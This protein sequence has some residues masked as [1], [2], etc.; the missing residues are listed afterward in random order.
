M[1]QAASLK[2]VLLGSPQITLD[3]ETLTGFVSAKAKALLCYLALTRRVHARSALGALLW[4]DIPEADAKSQ[5][6]IALSNLRK[7]TG[8]HLRIERETVEFDLTRPY[9]LDV[10]EF[11]SCIVESRRDLSKQETRAA[12]A[13]LQAATRL[14]RDD[15]LAGMVVR[16]A[17]E[18]EEWLL[19]QRERLRL[20][21]LDALWSSSELERAN[22]NSESALAALRRVIEME[23]WREEAHRELMLLY[24]RA[25]KYAP[26]LHQ[27]EK[28]RAAL[29]NELAVE[30]ARETAHLFERIRAAAQSPRR[31]LPL[32]PDVFVGRESEL[33]IIAQRFQNETR[34]LTL[35]GPGG[36]GKTRL[37]MQA[38]AQL[39]GQFLNGVFFV[40]LAEVT[41]PDAAV[42]A[43]AHAVQLTFSG[44]ETP[45]TQVLNYLQEK[46]LLLTL[47]NFEQVQN[48]AEIVREI[49][50]H[51]PAL[52]VLVTSRE[53]LNL[54]AEWLLVVEGLPTTL[55]APE[56]DAPSAAVQLFAER[57]RQIAPEFVLEHEATAVQQ[58]VA[59]LDGMPLAIELAAAWRRAYSATEIAQMVESDLDFLATTQPDARPAHASIRAV[60]QHSWTMLSAAE[61]QAFRAL[62][63]FHGG[64]AG[65]AA[66]QVAGITPQILQALADKSLLRMVPRADGGTLRFGLHELLR[67]YALEK[68]DQAVTGKN[69]LRTKHAD[70]YAQLLHVQEAAL[71]GAAVKQA[72][73]ALAREYDNLTAAWEW[74]CA[75]SPP[76]LEALKRMIGALVFFLEVRA[77][78]LAGKRMYT[79]AVECLESIVN[80]NA[81]LEILLARAYT[82]LSWFCFRLAEFEPGRAASERAL[83]LTQIHD[84]F[85]YIAYPLLFLGAC[86]FGAGKLAAARDWTWQSVQVFRRLND[87]FGIAGALNNLGQICLA[88]GDL[89]AA[90]EHLHRA[91]ETA[92]QAEIKTLQCNVLENL[93]AL[94]LRRAELAEAQRDLEAC[95]DLARELDLAY[96]TA[97][98]QNTLTRVCYERGD[99]VRAASLLQEAQIIWQRV[100]DR[101]SLTRTLNQ[102]ADLAFARGD[103]AQAE[104]SYL[105][106]LE[107]AHQVD[108]TTLMLNALAGLAELRAAQGDEKTALLWYTLLTQHEATE[109]STRAHAARRLQELTA[110][111]DAAVVASRRADA[112]PDALPKIVNE[113]LRLQN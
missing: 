85:E 27:Y 36:I 73:A 16:D 63:I 90:Q 14:Y 32:V 46:E 4:G 98:I 107:T 25:G 28:C 83:A 58:L 113:I 34:L 66:R 5:L 31:N 109:D 82:G 43:I 49:L 64:F 1:K 52:R 88:L 93:G 105:A 48:G 95:L 110:A 89:D 75:Q 81:D 67:Q 15:L 103:L 96:E 99:Y 20:M 112:M 100:G 37:A 7:L 18:F 92:R 45:R 84:A 101:W 55:A 77:E 42:L 102:A 35:L 23:P 61:Q 56:N 9:Y 86:E 78:Y 29:A 6:R 74:A 10:E 11:E 91:L 22:G 26:A 21:A 40:S 24:A 80:P 79:R 51:A 17:P 33:Q 76:Q 59:R 38:A 41:D 65:D 57:A 54:R 8:E 70:Y 3:D 97:T 104:K 13:Q 12:L 106:A 2:L 71:Q 108:A 44:N 72:T 19:I 30:P 87:A 62:A 111:L 94:R 50:E 68:L 39:S 69:E 47:D 53:R 60:F